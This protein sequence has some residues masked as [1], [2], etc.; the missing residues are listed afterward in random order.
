MSTSLFERMKRQTG[1]RNARVGVQHELIDVIAVAID[2]AGFHHLR[3][4]NLRQNSYT[5]RCSDR[6]QGF[7]L[8]RFL[9]KRP[10]LTGQ[11]PFDLGV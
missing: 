3:R 2:P 7:A 9:P 10:P 1:K 5:D 6:G 8:G 11:T 4:W